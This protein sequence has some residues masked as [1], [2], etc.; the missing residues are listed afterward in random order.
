MKHLLS[1]NSTVTVLFVSFNMLVIYDDLLS[2]QICCKLL[3]CPP[4]QKNTHKNLFVCLNIP[5][6]N[7][8]NETSTKTLPVLSDSVDKDDVVR[9]ADGDFGGVRRESHVIDNVAL[10]SILSKGYNESL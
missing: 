2:G 6:L 3:S 1:F 7:M 8:G 4:C 5:C 10:L 9:L